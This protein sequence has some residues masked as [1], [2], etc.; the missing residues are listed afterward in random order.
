MDCPQ[1][2][3]EYETTGAHLEGWSAAAA[4]A[5]A[6]WVA[7]AAA[8]AIE[9]DDEAVG[10]LLPMDAVAMVDDDDDEVEVVED[11]EELWEVEAIVGQR[12]RHGATP[13]LRPSAELPNLVNFRAIFKRAPK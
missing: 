1:C 12:V 9:E 11:A 6:G 8:A 5:A 7:P 13:P 10:P 4:A 3:D 2:V